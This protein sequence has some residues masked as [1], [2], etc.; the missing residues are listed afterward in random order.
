MK[1]YDRHVTST[2]QGR[3]SAVF[4]IAD[5]R[6]AVVTAAIYPEEPRN[7]YKRFVEYEAKDLLTGEIYGGLRRVQLNMGVEDGDEDTLHPATKWLEART[8]PFHVSSIKGRDTDGDQ[9]LVGF[10]N[11]HPL[12]GVILGVLG[13]PSGTYGASRAI[14]ERRYSIF[15]GTVVER[16]STGAYKI[17]REEEDSRILMEE[18]GDLTLEKESTQVHLSSTQALLKK[19]DTKVDLGEAT[20]EV[21]ALQIKLGS[22]AIQPVVLGTSAAALFASLGAAATAL[23]AALIP[24]AAGQAVDAQLPVPTIITSS[25]VQVL[26]QS[27]NAFALALN[28]ATATFPTTLSTKVKAE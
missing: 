24:I 10:I 4:A 3:R 25:A 26:I 16:L 12:N 9:V 21:E 19:G 15:K 23:S 2:P 11:G 6:V 20:A 7:R 13:H 17:E 8:E 22:T 28:A 14:S 27:L 1:L 18:N 5:L